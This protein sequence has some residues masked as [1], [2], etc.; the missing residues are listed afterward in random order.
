MNKPVSPKSGEKAAALSGRRSEVVRDVHA[1]NAGGSIQ[2]LDPMVVHGLVEDGLDVPARLMP[3]ANLSQ[4]LVV[5]VPRWLGM[6][7]Y[8]V[9]ALFW[10]DAPLDGV[11]GAYHEVLPTDMGA[12]TFELR[13]PPSYWSSVAEGEEQTFKLTYGARDGFSSEYKYGDIRDIQIDRLRP[14][15]NPGTLAPLVFPKRVEDSRRIEK[16]DFVSDLLRVEVKGY[17]AQ[18]PGHRITVTLTSG[19]VTETSGPFLTIS[20]V[21]VTVL[22]IPLLIFAS[23]PDLTPITITYRA[24][25]RAGNQSVTSETVVLQLLLRD[26]P[27]ILTPPE[28]PEF[29]LPGGRLVLDADA[30]KGI[31]MHVPHNPLIRVGDVIIATWDG[32]SSEPH[33]VIDLPADPDP[34]MTI[35]LLYAMTSRGRQTGILN[36]NYEVWRSGSKIGQPLTPATVDVDLRL[37]GGPDPDPD[38]G[39]GNLELATITGDVSGTPD[40]LT[41][42]DVATGAAVTIPLHAVDG[43]VVLQEGD[44]L[45]LLWG[46]QPPYRMEPVTDE[47]ATG[48]LDVVRPVPPTLLMAEP[49]GVVMMVYG[50]EREFGAGG[51]PN[52]SYS[53]P[54]PVQVIRAAD[55]PG[56]GG[57]LAAIQ[58]LG[59]NSFGAIDRT[60]AERTVEIRV[61][62]WS[63]AKA[64]DLLFIHLHADDR[65]RPPAGAP[66]DAAKV[67]LDRVVLQ[68]EHVD[69]GEYRT[70]LPYNWPF[71]VCVGSTTIEYTARNEHGGVRSSHDRIPVA[72]RMAGQDFCP[73]PSRGDVASNWALMNDLW[74]QIGVLWKQIN[75]RWSHRD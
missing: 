58:I 50:V 72:V 25:D 37:V 66:I 67:E 63:N 32:E 38:P 12:A 23:L 51:E 55:L 57:E 17:V 46:E 13:L 34:V 73:L 39:H 36:V 33:T 59:L 4:P 8:D 27:S 45:I 65:Q 29:G 40:E 35:R 6:K 22:Q 69:A 64:E 21:D 3:I 53:K 10:N 41:P 56:A 20:S 2:E 52:T 24:V 18:G 74:Q 43:T 62:L 30:R 31:E 48:G 9:V 71:I 16:S 7:E 1:P 44:E 11:A 47:E 28:I 15:G 61:P 19:A 49:S 14:G 54:K 60:V 70:H 68:Q 26:I 75:E 42:E 5:V